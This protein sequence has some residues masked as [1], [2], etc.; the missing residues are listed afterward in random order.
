[1]NRFIAAGRATKMLGILAAVVG[2]GV[3]APTALAG[4][5]GQQLVVMS[6][7]KV[8]AV[9]ISGENGNFAAVHRTISMVSSGGNWIGTTP[10]WWWRGS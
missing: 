7:V 8:P 1:V 2:T 10:N 6:P 3:A 9:T 5:S 4:S